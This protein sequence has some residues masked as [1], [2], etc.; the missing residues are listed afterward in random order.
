MSCLRGRFRGAK[1]A[2]RQGLADVNSLPQWWPL[3]TFVVLCLCIV[4]ATSHCI[5]CSTITSAWCGEAG[6]V[7]ICFNIPAGVCFLIV[8][9]RLHTSTKLT[10]QCCFCKV[11]HSNS[12]FAFSISLSSSNTTL[13]HLPICRLFFSL[14]LSLFLWKSSQPLPFYHYAVHLGAGV[15]F[16]GCLRILLI[17]CWLSESRPAIREVYL[18]LCS[19]RKLLFH[20][21]K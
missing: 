16:L 20:Y 18:I 2:V 7:F 6:G 5:A 10:L 4:F 8:H 21:F 15:H 11:C 3:C 17:D 14:S 1:S 13:I 19:G 12:R 9:E